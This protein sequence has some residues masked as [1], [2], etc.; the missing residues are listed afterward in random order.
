MQKLPLILYKMHS[1]RNNNNNNNNSN[2][3][4]NDQ[5][6]YS[7]Y[8]NNN[9]YYYYLDYRRLFVDPNMIKVYCQNNEAKGMKAIIIIII[10]IIIDY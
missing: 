9:N 2:T 4:N 6:Q 10:I 1:I 5:R 8:T 3:N 7:L